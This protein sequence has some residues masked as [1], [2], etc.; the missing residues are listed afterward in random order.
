MPHAFLILIGGMRAAH[1]SGSQSRPD[2]SYTET[3]F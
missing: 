2:F 1:D 3:V